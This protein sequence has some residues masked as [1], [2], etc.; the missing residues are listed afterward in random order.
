MSFEKSELMKLKTRRGSFKSLIA[1][2]S[3]FGWFYSNKS[4][5]A[6]KRSSCSGMNKNGF[7]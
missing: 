4:D 7:G 2:L 1:N 3:A 5:K 6:M